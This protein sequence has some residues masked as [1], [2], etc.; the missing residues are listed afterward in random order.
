MSSSE[1]NGGPLSVCNMQGN[2]Y[3]EMSSV[4]DIESDWMDLVETLCRKGC[5]LKRSQTNKYYL[6]L[7][8]R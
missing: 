3:C 8:V 2:Q 6:P 7:W 4:R 5:L 1:A